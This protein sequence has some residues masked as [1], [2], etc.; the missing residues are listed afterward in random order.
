MGETPK[1]APEILAAQLRGLESFQQERRGMTKEE[2]CQRFVAEMMKAAPIFDGTP[3]ELRAYAEE[4]AP[5]YFDMDDWPAQSPEQWA[6]D[7]IS[8]WEE[9]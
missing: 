7:D 2:F 6:R 1:I 3:E 4:V 5:T 8:Y 9:G